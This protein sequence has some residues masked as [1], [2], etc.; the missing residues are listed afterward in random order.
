MPA[1]QDVFRAEDSVLTFGQQLLHIAEASMWL[2][3]SA[4]GEK[5]PDQGNGRQETISAK[6]RLSYAL[7]EYSYEYAIMTIK[8]LPAASLMQNAKVKIG[9][10]I[11][12]IRLG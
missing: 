8:K 4:T 7:C 2:V 9:K 12:A 6:C 3:S 1:A 11:V 10:A 5:M